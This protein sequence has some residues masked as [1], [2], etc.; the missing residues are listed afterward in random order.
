MAAEEITPTITYF[1]KKKAMLV[2][3]A[4][5]DTADDWGWVDTWGDYQEFLPSRAACIVT[6]DS[7]TTAAVDIDIGGQFDKTLTVT[8]TDIDNITAKDTVTFHPGSGVSSDDGFIAWRYWKCD[9]VDEG[10]GNTLT[11]RLWLW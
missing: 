1:K 6:R 8:K 2:T 4:G 10:S 3:W 11:V 7:G 5:F 9:V